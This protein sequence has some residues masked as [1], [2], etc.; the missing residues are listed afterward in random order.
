M[1]ESNILL[2]WDKTYKKVEATALAQTIR[3][4]Y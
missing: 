1:T 3:R 4:F 2:G